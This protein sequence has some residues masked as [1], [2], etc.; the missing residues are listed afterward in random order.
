MVDPR[1][2]VKW[3]CLF[4]YDA[5]TKRNGRYLVEQAESYLLNVN[6]FHCVLTRQ[7]PKGRGFIHPSTQWFYGGGMSLLVHPRVETLAIP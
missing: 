1:G 2:Q 3:P 4:S 7:K 6:S 5:I